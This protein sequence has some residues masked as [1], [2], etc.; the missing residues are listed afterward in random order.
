[1]VQNHLLQALCMVAMEP[2][3]KFEADEIRSKKVDVLHAIREFNPGSVDEYVVRGQYGPGQIGD[4][5]V[6][7]YREEP[8]VHAGSNTETYVALKLFVDNWRWQDVPFYLRTGQTP[9]RKIIGRYHPIQTGASSGFSKYGNKFL[10]AQSFGHSHSSKRRHAT[11][12]SG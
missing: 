4:E 9:S 10:A 8:G 1:M 6:T 7:G 2:M 5:F 11:D 3:V 12:L